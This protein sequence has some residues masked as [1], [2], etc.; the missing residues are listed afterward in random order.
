MRE[1]NPQEF[2]TLTK[3]GLD[4]RA[5]LD[6]HVYLDL[7]QISQPHLHRQLKHSR[8]SDFFSRDSVRY[9]VY[10]AWSIHHNTKGRHDFI[11]HHCYES[12]IYFDNL[13]DDLFRD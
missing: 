6:T 13:S 10:P 1:K 8:N 2:A 9:R 5:A 4:I 3:Q 11:H 12:E 7:T